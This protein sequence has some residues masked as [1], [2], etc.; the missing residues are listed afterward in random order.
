[1]ANTYTIRTLYA[2]T[3]TQSV[4]GTPSLYL[5]GPSSTGAPNVRGMYICESR[6]GASAS[7]AITYRWDHDQTFSSAPTTYTAHGL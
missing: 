6:T 1:M 7:Q 4:T 5:Y 2:G 3:S